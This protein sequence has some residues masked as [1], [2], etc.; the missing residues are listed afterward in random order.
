MAESRDIR[1]QPQQETRF[2]EIISPDHLKMI[3]QASGG[4]VFVEDPSILPNKTG[5]TL[6]DSDPKEIHYNP[7]IFKGSPELGVKPIEHPEGFFY[8]E[9]GHHAPEV[10]EFDD[11]LTRQVLVPEN[12]PE[13]YKGSEAAE[14]RFFSALYRHF[15]NTNVDMWLES[16]LGRRPYYPIKESVTKFQQGKGAMESYTHFPKPEQLMQALLRSRYFEQ[17]NIGERLDADV[18]EAYERITRSG[19]MRALLDARDFENYFASPR[20]RRRAI[21]RKVL[22]CKEAMLPEYL[23][24]LE[25]ELEERKKQTQEAKGAEQSKPDEGGQNQPQQ[26]PSE[27]APLTKEE[28]QELVQQILKELEEAGHEAGAPSPDE[29]GHHEEYMGE[30]H[31]RIEKLH[32]TEV[33]E[34]GNPREIKPH[35]SGPEAGEEVIRQLAREFQQKEADRA[36]QGLAEAAQVR[37]ES[38]KE[39]ENIKQEYRLE[40]QSAASFLVEVFLDDRRKKLEYLVREGEVVPGLEYETIA[41]ILSGDIDPDTKMRTT[42]NPEFLETELEFIVDTSGS[43]AGDKIR[44]SIALLVIVAEALKRVK[45]DLAGEDLLMLD[46]EPLRVGVT[47]FAAAAERVTKLTD[48]LD[49]KKQLTIIDKLSQV[50]GGTEETGALTE[51]YRDLTV[52]KKNVIKI[53]IVLTDGAGNQEGVRPIIQQI[54]QDNEIVFLAAGLGTGEEEAQAI[55]KTYLESLQNREGGNVFGIAARN[56]NELLSRVLEFLKREVDK[57]RQA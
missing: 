16:F 35:E 30:L 44:K 8:H 21:E 42:R 31:R 11:D 17:S 28:E 55:V 46:E 36:R 20:D 7:L 47:K 29:Q 49:D 6:K 37:Q 38:I 22:A 13:S 3:S 51:V 14:K 26:P 25:N 54:E 4:Y 2:E 45:D 15:I 43:M 50:G 12:I 24:L 56:P 33:P 32:E 18:H 27:S 5:F 40:I 53:I 19:A 34:E 39:W 10:L 1:Q 9:A 57:R 23:K 52:D 41:A 48:P